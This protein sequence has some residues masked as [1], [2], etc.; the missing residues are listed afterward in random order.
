MMTAKEALATLVAACIAIV[1]GV[2]M[3]YQLAWALIIGGVL[4]LLVTVLLYDSQANQRRAD[5]ARKRRLGQG[6]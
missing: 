1:A 4:L 2:A 6:P 5:Q 3:L